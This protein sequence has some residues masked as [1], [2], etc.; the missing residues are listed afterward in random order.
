MPK[1]NNN[2]FLEV[3]LEQVPRL[4]GQLNRNQSSTTYGSFD[5]A[6]WHYRTNDISS[7]RYQEAVYTLALLYCSD[8]KENE[9]YHDYIVLKWIQASFTFT[10]SLQRSNG[11][12]DEWYIN[13]GS[14]VGTA[15][16]TA[17][18]SQA[19]LLLRNNKIAISQESL[20]CDVIKR[21]ADYLTRSDEQTVMNQA[22][23]AIFAVAVAGYVCNRDDLLSKARE[24]MEVFLSKQSKEGWWSEYGGPDIGYLSLTISYLEKYQKLTLSNEVDSPILKAKSFVEK[25]IHPDS[26]AGGEYMSR[27]TEY[28]IPSTTLPYFSAVKPVNLDDRYLC[29][30]LYNWIETG[31]QVPPQ[32]FEIIFGTDLFQESSLLRVANK[33]YFLIA[34]GKKGCSF[35]LY[36]NGKVYYDSGLEIST[37]HGKLSTGIL[38]SRNNV[39]FEKNY[40]QAQ[41]TA[42]K[43]KE[44]L[45]D[46]KV[47][48]VFKL[49]QFLF[50]RVSFLQRVVKNFLRPRMVS[51]SRGSNVSFDRKIEYHADHV[52]ITDIVHGV[53]SMDNIIFGSKGAYSAVPS[54]KYAATVELTGRMLSLKLEERNDDGVCIIKRNFSF[55]D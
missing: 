6:Y 47:A 26:S 50:G 36:S 14:Y 39:S 33:K 15:F 34:N 3:S 31:V 10:A 38:D 5:R 44:P 28:I 37:P 30:I 46:T 2:K 18:L 52:L 13:E 19:V 8:F 49:W 17:A 54:S 45:Q 40:I 55:S 9:Y 35:R 42:K 20:I 12:F 48:I 29:Y 11:S 41:G 21:A 16:L 32:T 24:L 22:S 53:F 4:L 1:I 51:Y 23:G 25:F 7:C 27:N 43:I